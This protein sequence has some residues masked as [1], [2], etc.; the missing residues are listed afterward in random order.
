M[1]TLIRPLKNMRNKNLKGVSYS[2]FENAAGKFV[3][4][5]KQI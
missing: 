5:V 4:E 1:E 3:E 2:K